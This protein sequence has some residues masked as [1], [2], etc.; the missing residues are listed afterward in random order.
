MEKRLRFLHLDTHYERSPRK[1]GLSYRHSTRE[2]TVAYTITD[3]EVTAAIAFRCAE[4][5]FRRK[6]GSAQARKNFET[7]SFK[8]HLPYKNFPIGLLTNEIVHTLNRFYKEL[9]PNK[10]YKDDTLLMMRFSRRTF[11]KSTY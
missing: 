4:D 1:E 10:P 9:I 6:A 5:V 3:D 2:S 7:H 8:F 11:D